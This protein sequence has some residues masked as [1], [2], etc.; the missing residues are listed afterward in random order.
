MTRR[1]MHDTR[2][3][4]RMTLRIL[5]DYISE[6]GMHCSYATTLGAGGLFIESDAPPA[7]GSMLKMRFR[8]PKGEELHEIEGRVVWQNRPTATTTRSQAPGFGVKF[9]EGPATAQLAR[10]IEDYY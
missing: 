1:T 7:C 3:F 4:R 5:V 9:C 6:S 10:E 2:R 8:L